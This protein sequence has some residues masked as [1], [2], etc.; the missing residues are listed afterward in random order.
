VTDALADRYGR[1]PD[2]R[3]FPL[4]LVMALVVGVPFLVW[5]TWVVWIQATPAVQSTERNFTIVDEHLAVATIEVT[6]ADDAVD[7]VCRMRALAAD[8]QPVGDTQ[9]TP[10]HGDNEVEIRTERKATAV[11]LIG[12]TAEGQTTPR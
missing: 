4:A 10:V 1:R 2:G 5:L 9:F 11:E 8:K 6:L 12:C 7:P 3:R